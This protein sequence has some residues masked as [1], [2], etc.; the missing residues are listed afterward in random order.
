MI[1]LGIGGL[2]YSPTTDV[3]SLVGGGQYGNL[4]IGVCLNTE[5][6]NFLQFLYNTKFAK[7][8]RIS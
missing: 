2:R 8:G 3:G 7:G 5:G 4:N 1:N 6:E